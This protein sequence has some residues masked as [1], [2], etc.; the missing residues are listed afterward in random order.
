VSSSSSSSLLR[1]RRFNE[2]YFHKEL[3]KTKIP[4]GSSVKKNTDDANVKRE[5]SSLQRVT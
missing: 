4:P 1:A 2:R 5:L 3:R